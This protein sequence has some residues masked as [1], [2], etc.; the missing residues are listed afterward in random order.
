M[1]SGGCG[2]VADTPG[3]S[4]GGCCRD[5]PFLSSAA[6]L[7]VWPYPAA[8]AAERALLAAASAL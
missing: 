1:G 2:V 5:L 3:E 4:S 7:L 6:A 8:R